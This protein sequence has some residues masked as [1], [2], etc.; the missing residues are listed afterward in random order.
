MID[1]GGRNNADGHG[2]FVIHCAVAIERVLQ[3]ALEYNSWRMSEN[4]TY[5][6][7]Y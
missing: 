3:N 7:L 5:C 2:V 6:Q 1:S 4:G